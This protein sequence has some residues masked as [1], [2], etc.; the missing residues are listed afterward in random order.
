MKKRIVVM[1]AALVMLCGILPAYA[2]GGIGTTDE[3]WYVVSHSGDY[4]VYFFAE[5]MNTSAEPEEINDLLFEIRDRADTTI[6]STSKYKL[7][8]EILEP[9]QTGWLVISQDVKDIETK[10]LI[11]HYALTITSK[12]NDDKAAKRLTAS[13]EYLKEDE[14][15]NEDVIRATV[16]NNGEGNAFGLSAALAVR[17]D[18]GKL[19]YVAGT[20]TKDIGLAEGGSLLIRSEINSDIMDALKD[21]GTAIASAEA[22]AYTVEDLD[23]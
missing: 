6:E 7:Y 14:D 15:E 1:L 2:A 20:A 5:V 22:V 19:L 21:A 3:T 17:G 12:R 16:T 4:R 11:D 18:D 8:P 13:A 10:S 23:D 9:G